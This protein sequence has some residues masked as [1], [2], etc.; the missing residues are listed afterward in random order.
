[1][2]ESLLKE[3]CRI[4]EENQHL[5]E[6]LHNCT[7]VIRTNF[8][9]VAQLECEIERLKDELENLTTPL[10][11]ARA[12]VSGEQFEQN[13]VEGDKLIKE[14]VV[15]LTQLDNEPLNQSR[16]KQSKSVAE[17]DE[18]SDIISCNQLNGNDYREKILAQQLALFGEQ[19]DILMDER[20]NLMGI[21]SDLMKTISI[22]RTE[23]C[24]YNF[25]KKQHKFN[26]KI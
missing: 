2:V 6:E 1:M 18:E 3:Y 8:D 5:N 12:D 7:E 24:A 4:I 20:K 19:I 25:E 9:V 26:V 17:T 14:F 16:P 15:K 23:L 22:C 11:L 13:L 10:S 21:N